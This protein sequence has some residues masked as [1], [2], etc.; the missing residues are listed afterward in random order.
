VTEKNYLEL[1]AI[2]EHAA[3]L[4]ITQVA[5]SYRAGEDFAAEAKAGL[6]NEL[7]KALETAVKK[8]LELTMDEKLESLAQSDL[9]CSM[10]QRTD[11]I[12][13]RTA[14]MFC[15]TSFV[16]LTAHPEMLEALIR[17]NFSCNQIC[18]YCW[19]DR[20][21]PNPDPDEILTMIAKA[22]RDHLFRLSFSG[23]E[24]TINKR[25][26]EYIRAAKDAGI[27]ETVI[28]T[29]AVMLANPDLCIALDEAGLDI[30]YV[31]MLAENATLSD[32]ITR[33]EGTFRKTVQGIQNL[34]LK[35][36]IF[37]FIHFVITKH[38]YTNLP[39][40]IE[41]VDALLTSEAGEKVPITF[42]YV[43]PPR[44]DVIVHVP[45]YSEAVPYLKR[46]MELCTAK[47]IP[48]GGNEGLKS[49]PP[50]MLG[51]DERYFRA[52]VPLNRG[53]ASTD[54]VK[55]PDCKECC[56]DRYCFGVRKIYALNFGLDEIQ[57][58]RPPAE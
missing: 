21:T 22:G 38:N 23:G 1:S 9:L 15:P 40:F 24:P 20:E 36:D 46:A 4:G 19:V 13:D 34:L 17:T 16:G 55:K 54:Y 30:A 28:H 8:K 58:I 6:Q 42:S 31:T 3:E 10:R 47:G 57:P 12:D 32:S 45:R 26:P 18:N 37:T 7:S 49:L 25:L 5:M 29:N 2:V 56:C 44:P 50:C 51:G 33:T 35:T 43:A 48:F 41:F 27:R 53:S 11:E 39:E 14:T 52:L